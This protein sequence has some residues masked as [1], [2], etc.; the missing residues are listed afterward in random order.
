MSGRSDESAAICPKCK[1]PK[2]MPRDVIRW[3]TNTGHHA[4]VC[5]DGVDYRRLTPEEEAVP[6]ATFLKERLI[7]LRRQRDRL[8]CH[9]V[10]AVT[11]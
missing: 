6:D 8:A 2:A 9:A 1:R 4:Q 11:P 3:L 10:A 5:W 7:E